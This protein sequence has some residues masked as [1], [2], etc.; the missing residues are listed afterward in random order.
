[1]APDSPL[2]NHAHHP[3]G[4]QQAL[5]RQPKWASDHKRVTHPLNLW[6]ELGVADWLLH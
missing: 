1:M 4:K 6:Q 2:L 5:L 3:L